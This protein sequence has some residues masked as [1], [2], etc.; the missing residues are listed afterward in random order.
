MIWLMQ[1]YSQ[2][3][4]IPTFKLHRVII[5]ILGRNVKFL[6]HFFS[7]FFGE[8][9]CIGVIGV[10]FDGPRHVSLGAGGEFWVCLGVGMVKKIFAGV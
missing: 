4:S 6:F 1:S 3:K 7:F 5:T 10:R 8:T 9:G 2:S